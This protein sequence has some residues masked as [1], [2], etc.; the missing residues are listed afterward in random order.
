MKTLNKTII[1]LTLAVPVLA[2]SL[3]SQAASASY[4]ENAL[5]DICE[6]A[7]TN[8]IL[9]LKSTIKS[10]GLKYKTVASKVMCNGDDIVTFS[11]KNGAFDT[12]AKLQDSIPGTVITDIAD[13]KETI[14]INDNYANNL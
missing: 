6:A 13:E 10:Y 12:A 5:V 7:Q 4:I 11:Q 2:F 3:S 14:L 1:T 8:K 9:K